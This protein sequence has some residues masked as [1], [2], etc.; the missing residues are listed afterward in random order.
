MNDGDLESNELN[1]IELFTI[2]QLITI[3]NC[4]DGINIKSQAIKRIAK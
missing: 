2:L 1:L 3:L 4:S